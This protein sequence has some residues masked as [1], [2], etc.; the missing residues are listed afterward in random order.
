MKIFY[1][2]FFSF[3]YFATPLVSQQLPIFTQ[4]QENRSYL[5]PAALNSSFF[6]SDHNMSFGMTHRSQWI[7]FEAGPQTQFIRGD[8][9]NNSVG[10]NLL[11][12]GY[13]MN[14]KT[15]PISTTSIVGKIGAIISDDPSYS[16]L[17]FALSGGMV[18]YR[19]DATN[20]AI[21]D[22]NDVDAQNFTTWYPDL[23]LGAFYYQYINRKDVVFAGLSIPQVFGLNLSFEGVEK[24]F[25]LKRIQHAYVML[26]YIKQLEASN[27]FE[28]SSWIRYAPNAPINADIN[29]RYQFSNSFWA[30]IGGSTAGAVHLEA[31][32]VLDYWNIGWDNKG[33]RLGY[34]FNHFFTSYGP[35]SSFGA[36]HELN[37]TYSLA[38]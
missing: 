30:G 16:G 6:I 7:G 33:I 38:N 14:D 9:F 15:D 28:A 12:G 31:G 19:F 34:S 8:Y 26:G 20:L 10:V 3:L 11:A 36:A 17:S 23:G 1:L 18:Q 4:Y 21:R 13:L 24:E 29:I 35:S 25:N 5:N 32:L 2:I 37:L 22:L 27:Y